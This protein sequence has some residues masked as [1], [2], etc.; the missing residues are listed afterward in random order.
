MQRGGEIVRIVRQR[1]EVLAL[2]NYRAFVGVGIGAERGVA[3]CDRDLLL[4]DGGGELDVE[5][6]TPAGRDFDRFV[7]EE[8]KSGCNDSQKVL[9]RRETAEYIGALIVR[10]SVLLDVV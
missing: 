10:R 8:S 6:L 9:A 5:G 2:E 7:L 1:V 3:G 4:F